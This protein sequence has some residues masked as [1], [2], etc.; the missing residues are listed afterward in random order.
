[1][2]LLRG[3]RGVAV[4]QAGEHTAQCLDTE[5]QRCHVEQKHILDVTLQNTGLNS[6]TNRH[7][8]IRV[9]AFV[10]LFAEEVFHDF[11]DFRHAC[12]AADKNHFADIAR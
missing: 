7:H 2:A 1:M 3:D 10:R 6:G 12:H 8:F 4:N 11:L 9:D 5:R